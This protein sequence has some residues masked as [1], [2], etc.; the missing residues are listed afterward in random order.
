MRGVGWARV[1]KN[2]SHPNEWFAKIGLNCMS[3]L[4]YMLQTQTGSGGGLSCNSCA[5]NN[6]VLVN[7]QAE[8]WQFFCPNINHD[9]VLYLGCEI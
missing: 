4:R 2:P 6:P 9:A 3:K 1:F 7:V 5:D 8:R